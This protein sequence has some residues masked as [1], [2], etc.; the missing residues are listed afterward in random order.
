MLDLVSSV[1]RFLSRLLSRLMARFARDA[2]TRIAQAELRS[3]NAAFGGLVFSDPQM[4]W[5]RRG[6]PGLHP[7][8]RPVYIHR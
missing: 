3:L 6:C 4:N 7:A 5:M 1:L 8:I 2:F